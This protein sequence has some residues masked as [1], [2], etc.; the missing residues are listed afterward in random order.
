MKVNV[1]NRS[2]VRA[3]K[4]LLKPDEELPVD[5]K[6]LKSAYNIVDVD[7]AL[8]TRGFIIDFKSD[9]DATFFLLRFA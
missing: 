4:A 8:G 5:F 3:T 9:A 2:Y 7:Y 6:R 1:S